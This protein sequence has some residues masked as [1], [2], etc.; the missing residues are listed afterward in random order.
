MADTYKLAVGY[1]D[2]SDSGKG[3]SNIA[4]VNGTTITFGP[5]SN[6]HTSTVNETQWTE[7]AELTTT[8][9]LV[10]W[11]DK[12]PWTGRSRVATVSGTDITWGIETVWETPGGTPSFG[13]NRAE[14]VMLSS[15]SV[16]ISYRNEGDGLA[17]FVS[18]V[19]TISGNDITWGARH[20]HTGSVLFVWAGSTK[21]S[22]TSVLVCW[23]DQLATE[24]WASILTISGTNI[25]YGPRKS[26]GASGNRRGFS[27]DMLDSTKFVA[28]WTDTGNSNH[29]VAA[30][31][32]ISGT[33]ITLGAGVEFLSANG[34]GNSTGN[35]SEVIALSA[36]KCIMVYRDS[37]DLNHGV[38]R[39]G[40]VSGN[41]IT[42]GVQT[43]FR[44]GAV[45]S[46]HGVSLN[47]TQFFTAYTDGADLN[48]GTAKIGTVSG[49]TVTFGT[50]TEF[51]SA[52]GSGDFRIGIDLLETITSAGTTLLLAP[53]NKVGNK[54]IA[55]TGGKQ[56]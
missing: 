15:T 20:Q 48:H 5:K 11:S 49:T 17:P 10:V 45:T 19:G 43:K 54:F 29:G 3:A 47:S 2:N 28:I 13:A 24:G 33:D 52:N 44:T 36:T 46:V 22:S 40:T 12:N 27:V 41:D 25:T 32:T 23:H 50:E 51:L 18:K 8:K 21:I 42:F 16:I 7:I 9:F 55:K 4:E 56:I 30:V 14:L 1:E 34:L 39:V 38:C 35:Q 26:F 37:S 31:G 53:P 6:F